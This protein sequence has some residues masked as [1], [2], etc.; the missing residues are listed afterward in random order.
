MHQWSG[1]D[2]RARLSGREIRINYLGHGLRPRPNLSQEERLT[3]ETTSAR[4][5]CCR[6]LTG[7]QAKSQRFGLKMQPA[8]DD[9]R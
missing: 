7:W 8:V 4:A 5:A 6:S 9:A 2:R 1:G 3:M